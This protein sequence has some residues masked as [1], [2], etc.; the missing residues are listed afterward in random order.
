[1]KRIFRLTLL[2]AAL[3]VAMQPLSAQFTNPD[4]FEDKLSFFV[5]NDLGRNG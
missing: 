4:D 2:A 1:M 3:L 5:A